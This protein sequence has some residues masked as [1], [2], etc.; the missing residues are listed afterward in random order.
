MFEWKH[1][2]TLS[3]SHRGQ[4]RG[5]M[6]S[7]WGRTPA[8]GSQTPMVGSMTPS[9]GSMTPMHSGGGRTPM[10]GSH[11][12]MHGDGERDRESCQCYLCI[13]FYLRLNTE[14]AMYL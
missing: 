13:V 9:Y 12:P 14:Y 11:T 5:G 6:T 1:T 4:D 2:H 7:T 3:F 10:Y 8:F